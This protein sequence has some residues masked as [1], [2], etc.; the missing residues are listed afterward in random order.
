[1]QPDLAV[2]SVLPSVLVHHS[3]VVEEIRTPDYGF[4]VHCFA[5]KLQPPCYIGTPNTTLIQVVLL[6]LETQWGQ[7]GGI[8]LPYP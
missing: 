7:V 1:M 5:T 8:T 4:T 3:G 2:T 6:P